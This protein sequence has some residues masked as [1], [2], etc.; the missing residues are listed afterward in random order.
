MIRRTLHPLVSF[1][2]TMG[3]LTHGNNL[4]AILPPIALIISQRFVQQSLMP[5]EVRRLRLMALTST[6]AILQRGSLRAILVTS[7]SKKAVAQESTLFR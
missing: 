2:Q 4:A 7:C 5:S 3:I 1:Q 6:S